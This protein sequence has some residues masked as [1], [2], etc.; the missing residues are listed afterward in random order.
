MKLRALIAISYT[1]CGSVVVLAAQ[2]RSY[3]WIITVALLTIP[4]VRI[5]IRHWYPKG[6]ISPVAWPRRYESEAY[7]QN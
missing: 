6:S 7:R 5:H 3:S 1:L 4:I 2:R